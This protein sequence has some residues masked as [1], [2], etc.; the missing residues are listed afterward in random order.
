MLGQQV[1]QRSAPRKAASAFSQCGIDSGPR[2]VR[3][4][5]RSGCRSN[6]GFDGP[7]IPR[8]GWPRH[9]TLC[10][11]STAGALSRML[12]WDRLTWRSGINDFNWGSI[13]AGPNGKTTEPHEFDRLPVNRRGWSSSS[14]TR[15]SWTRKA[16]STCQTGSKAD[17]DRTW[18]ASSDSSMKT[19]TNPR[20]AL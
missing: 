3:A 15:R 5:H 12:A 17:C 19:E 11:Q 16:L 14:A 4:C 2:F 13:F 9:S 18:S 8:F 10:L 6:L 1:G 7:V 20:Q